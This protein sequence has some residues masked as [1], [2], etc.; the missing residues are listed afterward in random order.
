MWG[1]VTH[2][3]NTWCHVF[4]FRPYLHLHLHIYIYICNIIFLDFLTIYHMFF[5]HIYMYI[6]I[7]YINICMVIHKVNLSIRRFDRAMI[8][9]AGSFIAPKCQQ[10]GVSWNSELLGPEPSQPERRNMPTCLV[11]LDFSLSNIPVFVGVCFVLGCFKQ[12]VIK[13]SSWELTC[14]PNSQHLFSRWLSVLQVGDV[15]LLKHTHFGGIKVDANLWAILRGF[16]LQEC[17]VWVGNSMMPAPRMESW[18]AGWHDI[19]WF[20][21][22]ELNLHFI[23]GILLSLSVRPHCHLISHTLATKWKA[24]NPL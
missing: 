20:R 8:L 23:T 3:E 5:S 7:S 15:S 6:W 12:G 1:F 21:D 17:I 22:P 19:F 24:S 11:A 4:I 9:D 16:P 10:V 14:P 2:C 18:P 13:W